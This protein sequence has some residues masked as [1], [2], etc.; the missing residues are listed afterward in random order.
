MGGAKRAGILR[1]GFDDSLDELVL[2]AVI[3]KRDVELTTAH[4]A[5]PQLYLCHAYAPR[6]LSRR[7]RPE[8]SATLQG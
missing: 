8:A 3:L 7:P 2:L 4:E 6:I 5:N 1:K